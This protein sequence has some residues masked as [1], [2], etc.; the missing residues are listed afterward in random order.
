M[1]PARLKARC[2]SSP[3]GRAWL[4]ALPEAVAELTRHWQLELAAPFDGPGVGC[5]WVAT[6]RRA[7]GSPA[8]LKLGMPHYE[9]EHEL[10][11]LRFWDG[12]PTVR[13]LEAE[14]ALGALLLERCEPGTALRAQGE[15]EQDRV[16]AQLLRRLWRPPAPNHPFRPL[17]AMLE[18][19]SRDV[20]A[21]RPAWP[22]PALMR[23]ALQLFE[24]L[25][26]PAP[27]D[28]VLATDLHAGNVLCAKREPWLAIDPKPF[29]GDAAYDATQHLLNCHARLLWRP[30]ETIQRFADALQVSAERVRLWIFARAAS[31]LG[32][33][34]FVGD[35]QAIARKLA[36]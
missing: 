36:P 1:I 22:E 5:S 7:D 21:A 6:A 13:V 16:L 25:S 14:Q 11:G 2:G 27:T 4:R 23:D 24:E 20:L 26:R 32:S 29:V 35:A 17:S 10:E 34:P 19:W 12:D 31:Q 8:V 28:V 30:F 3:D 15:P 9:A 33:A 18:L